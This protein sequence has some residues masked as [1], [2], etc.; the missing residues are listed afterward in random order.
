MADKSEKKRKKLKSARK[1]EHHNIVQDIV[2]DIIPDEEDTI[3]ALDEKL[4][5]DTEVNKE[6]NMIYAEDP[7]FHGHSKLRVKSGEI[8]LALLGVLIGSLGTI[9]VMIP[10]D[11]TCGGLGGVSRMI[12]HYSGWDY[13]LIYYVLAMV[14][15]IVVWFRLG[16]KELR[17]IIFMS[18]AYPVVMF[19][20]ELSGLVIMKSDDLLLVSLVVGCFF[21]VSNGITF[22]AGF[23]SGGSDSLAKIIKY[24]WMPHM[25]INYLNFAINVFVIIASVIAFGV[26]IAMYAVVIT[27]VSTRVG[28]AV[29]YGI[30][31]R[32]VELNVVSHH[33]EEL[34]DF[35]IHDLGRGATSLEITGGYTGEK[36]EQVKIICTPRESF[37]IKRYLAKHDPKAF[38]SIT[39]VTSVWGSGKGFSDIKKIDG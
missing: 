3:E 18:F 38:V 29:M 34:K 1:K 17:K 24:R 4:E 2:Q 11:L 22:K 5:K 32:I 36:M 28:E 30:G 6:A 19:L 33:P 13:S 21:G 10:N 31:G 35:V 12:Q 15:A 20:I 14:V 9:S 27:F 23:S 8:A 16:A 25:S 7:E 26:N 37:I 39:S